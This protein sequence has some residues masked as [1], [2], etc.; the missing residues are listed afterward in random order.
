MH[1]TI[2]EDELG[3][4]WV[5]RTPI[6]AVGETHTGGIVDDLASP[7][8]GAAAAAGEEGFVPV[9]RFPSRNSL[10]SSPFHQRARYAR[11]RQK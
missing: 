4:S 1:R 10:G 9:T 7:A 2:G 3:A 5:S 8:L 6:C 11:C